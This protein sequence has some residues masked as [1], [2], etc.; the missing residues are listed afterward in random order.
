MHAVR[1]YGRRGD[2][3]VDTAHITAIRGRAVTVREVEV[4]VTY[5]AGP[6]GLSDSSGHPLTR[7]GPARGLERSFDLLEIDHRWLINRI[8]NLK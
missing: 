4:L 6:S 1:K 5:D 2:H 3:Y 8:E 7:T